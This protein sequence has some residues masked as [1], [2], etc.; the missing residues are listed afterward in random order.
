MSGFTKM[1]E[2]YGVKQV[3]YGHLHGDDAKKNRDTISLNGTKYRLV[4]LDAI[5]CDPVL[6]RE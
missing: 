6:I 3:Y 4:S 2:E 5:D 1:F